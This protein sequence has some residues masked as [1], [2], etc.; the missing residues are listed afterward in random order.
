MYKF[1]YFIVKTLRE[2]WLTNRVNEVRSQLPRGANIHEDYLRS[3]ID[4][5]H[6][7]S[8]DQ[9]KKLVFWTK[10][11]IILPTLSFIDSFIHLFIYSYFSKLHINKI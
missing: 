2:Q 8:I 6:T 7:P 3:E 5:N 11:S 9:F 10:Q 4:R 1:F